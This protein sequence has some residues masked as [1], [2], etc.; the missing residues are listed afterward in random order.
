MNKFLVLAIILSAALL[1]AA[2]WDA[3]EI[4]ESAD[5]DASTVTIKDGTLQGVVS[6]KSRA[7]YGVPFA[8][9]PVKA[10][11]WKDP[12]P[13]VPW[14]GVR[15]AKSFQA[16]CIQKC[17]L[18]EGVC[19][20]VTSEDCLY[21]DVYTPLIAA[22]EDT[23][24]MPVMVFIPGGAFSM[25]AGGVPLYNATSLVSNANMIVVNINYRLGVLGFLGADSLSGN[26]GLLDQIA[27]LEWIR[28]NIAAFGGDAA[29][30]TI[31]GESAGGMSVNALLAS[32]AA[33]GLFHRAITQ[34]SPS[35]IGFKTKAQS[36]KNANKFAK[37]ANCADNDMV[38]MN[39]LTSDQVLTAQAGAMSGIPDITQLLDT[40]TPWCPVLEAGLVPNQSLDL[41]SA[42]K[43]NQVPLMIGTC[44]NEGILFV[45]AILK[46]KV[47][48]PVYLALTTALFYP[49][50]YKVREIYTTSVLGDSRPVMSTIVNDYLFMCPAR[51]QSELYNQ[52]GLV[53]Y[54]YKFTHPP[55][56]PSL[57]D[58]CVG[59]VCHGSELSF[60][61]NTFNALGG[62]TPTK[63]EQSLSQ[64][65]G[66]YW[67]NFV[68]NGDPNVGI[69][70]DSEWPEY[71]NGEKTL[72][73]ETPPNV[74]NLHDNKGCDLFDSLG[75]NG[76][77]FSFDRNRI[78]ESP[79]VIRVIGDLKSTSTYIISYGPHSDPLT[80][81][82]QGSYFSF[83]FHADIIPKDN[84]TLAFDVTISTN[85]V[86]TIVPWMY[87]PTPCPKDC[88]SNGLCN[89]LVGNC[90]CDN[91]YA[92]TDCSVPLIDFPSPH[93]YVQVEFKDDVQFTMLSHMK[94]GRNSTTKKIVG[95]VDYNVFPL[96]QT[97]D[98]G[99]LTNTITISTNLFQWD[100]LNQDK[101]YAASFYYMYDPTICQDDNGFKVT[102][103]GYDNLPA[104]VQVDN[105][106]SLVLKV[107]NET[108]NANMEVYSITFQAFH[109]KT[110]VI[111]SV[112]SC[113]TL[114]GGVI[115]K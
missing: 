100:W 108:S 4:L 7:F 107:R 37:A 18:A 70:V 79:D 106:D 105:T 36:Q 85:G 104:P 62:W 26:F 40:F 45:Y 50:A 25:G 68:I 73:F 3:S 81:N 2:E 61:F 60:V 56:N 22:R 51:I 87:D 48:Y 103:Q 1:V 10:L 82:D 65:M 112:T 77:K 92:Y 9:P 21:L 28:E 59:K 75:Y 113:F 12:A 76:Q 95:I 16:G 34:S 99:V 15:P 54:H 83:Y 33:A 29:Q 93:P 32:P 6:K 17:T 109:S 90:T 35:T 91:G 13:V 8:A 102:I 78:Y 84:D 23:A 101:S 52:D 72:V 24:L 67:S 31:S 42:G 115:V 58:T 96:T 97:V 30:V 63:A 57:A 98:D 41:I 39:A 43:F 19:P 27:A 55:S 110:L 69:T 20:A 86:P 14:K 49:N 111:Q 44:A 5:A 38:C 71:S 89:K 74:Q 66:A 114:S 94:I 47:R 53:S 11:R 46:E 64:Q 88:N 80:W